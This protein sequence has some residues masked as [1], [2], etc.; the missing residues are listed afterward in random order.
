MVRIYAFLLLFSACFLPLGGCNTVS[1][2]GADMS[3]AGHKIRD[4]SR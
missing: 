3:A 2:F 4:V 1:G